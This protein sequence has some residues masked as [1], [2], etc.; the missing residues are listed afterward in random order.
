M[1]TVNCNCKL[2]G[3]FLFSRYLLKL[4]WVLLWSVGRTN[5]SRRRQ[6]QR[7]EDAENRSWVSHRI[8]TGK[9]IFFSSAQRSYAINLKRTFFKWAHYKL[10]HKK[11][12]ACIERLIIG[13]LHVHELL[14]VP[15]VLTPNVLLSV[16]STWKQ[17]L[18]LYL[19]CNLNLLSPN[20]M[21]KC[22]PYCSETDT[23]VEWTPQQR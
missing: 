22:K 7:V 2:F 8:L 21:E 15:S 18:C 5:W 13:I 17:M 6:S 16:F 4:W 14:M 19:D 10:K 9:N 1:T 20:C 3:N 23:V 11:H 12:R